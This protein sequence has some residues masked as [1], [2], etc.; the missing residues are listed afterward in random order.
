[1]CRCFDSF[2][3]ASLEDKICA[4]LDERVAKEK[5]KKGECSHG[6]IKMQQTVG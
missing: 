2:Y 4:L 1:M 5:E 3:F 6:Y